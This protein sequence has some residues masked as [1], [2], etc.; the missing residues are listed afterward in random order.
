MAAD[1]ERSH[2]LEAPYDSRRGDRSRAVRDDR[3]GP[4]PLQKD[5][6]DGVSRKQGGTVER[7]FAPHPWKNQ[8]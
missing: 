6:S 8:G 4:F 1:R 2:R 7:M 3:T 5:T